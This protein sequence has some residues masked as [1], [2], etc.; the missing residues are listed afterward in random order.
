[1]KAEDYLTAATIAANLGNIF[2][3]EK[4]FRDAYSYYVYAINTLEGLTHKTSFVW[5]LLFTCHAEIGETYLELGEL[6]K[7]E[8]AFHKAAEIMAHHDHLAHFEFW[9]WL[10]RAKLYHKQKYRSLFRDSLRKAELLAKDGL[11][12]E[13]LNK[14]K[15]SL[16][17]SPEFGDEISQALPTPAQPEP[18]QAGEQEALLQQWENIIKI[19]KLL[20]SEHNL[21]YL[22]RLVLNFALE[23]ADAESGLVILLNEKNELEVKAW[24]NEVLS[25]ELTRFS[26][27]VANECLQKGDVII[28][29]DAPIDERFNQTQS[30]VLNDLKSILCLPLKSRNKITGV[31]YLDNRYKTDAFKGVN[32]RILHAYADQVGLALENAHLIAKYEE[33]QQKLQT[34]LHETQDELDEVKEILKNEASISMNRYSYEHIIGRSQPMREI[35]KLLDKIT[36]TNLA[37]FL[38]GASGTGKELIA[39]AIHYNNPQRCDKR[40]VAI[41]CGAIPANLMESELFGYKAGSFT[42]ATKDKKGLFEEASGGTLFLDEVADLE[43]QLQVKL[44]RVLQEG[45]VQRIGEVRPIKVDVRIVSASHKSL[46]DL[47]GQGKFRED[48]FYRLCQMKITLPHLAERKEDIPLLVE[49][50]INEYSIENKVSE[51]INVQPTLMKAFFA[52]SWPGNIRELGNCIQVA[53][54]LREKN[55][56][57]LNSLPQNHALLRSI[58]LQKIDEETGSESFKNI[59]P[60]TSNVAIDEH[61][62]LTPQKTWAE[63]EILIIAKCYAHHQFQKNLTSD[64]LGVSPATL[65]NK[66]KANKLDEPQNALFKEPFH[67]EPH[68]PLKAYIPKIFKAALIYNNDHPYA[69]IKQLA[70]SQGYFYKIMKSF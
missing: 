5:Q 8:E 54:A 66:I 38:N 42:G 45:E 10:Q 36:E 46:D 32:L 40:F 60:V 48:L 69:A 19:N 39:R 65:Y 6:N 44:L 31:L 14:L 11:E 28:S 35:F 43:P 13:S 30:I 62:F 70:V 21:D 37:I 22:L 4:K 27:S 68:T 56:I 1:R 7:S 3:S 63:Y 49:H 34:K 50:F 51:K 57:T 55:T 17:D 29:A 24:V 53:C 20:N 9:I 33:V 2:V 67:Y 23:L 58:S 52:Y 18:E 25:D 41:N 64:M 61:N 12:K 59:K 47:V 16:K 26:S 15:D